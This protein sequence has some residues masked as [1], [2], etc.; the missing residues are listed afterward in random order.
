MSEAARPID[1]DEPILRRIPI[2]PGYFDPA[3]APPVQAGAFRPHPNDHDGLSFYRERELS[4]AELV[5]KTNKAPGSFA[6]ARLKARELMDLGLT[7]QP[8]QEE[9]DLPG[10]LIVPEINVNTYNDPAQRHRVKKLCRDLT[11]LVNRAGV[12]FRPDVGDP[13]AAG[14]QE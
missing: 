12:T 5:A 11:V 9:G 8:K 14:P 13:D 2:V 6:I 7:L 4:V 3:K 10:H 1:P